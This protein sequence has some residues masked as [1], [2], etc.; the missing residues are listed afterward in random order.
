MQEQE[1]EKISFAGTIESV[2]P[3]SN[4]W[5]YRVD[6]RTHRLTGYNIFLRGLANGEEKDFAIAVSE[7][8]MEKYRFHIGDEI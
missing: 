3:R 5:R 8:Q 7:K 1:Q 2:Q 6:N 4:V